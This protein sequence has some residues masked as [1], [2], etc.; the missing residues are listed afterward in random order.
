[1]QAELTEQLG[2]EKNGAGDK[3][4]E[5]RRN[6]KS[7]KTLRPDQGPMEVEAPRDR[8]GEFEPVIAAKLQRE[9]RG[10]DDKIL[11]VYGLGLPAKAVQENLKDIY[12]VDVS[13]ELVSRVTDEVKGLAG[14]WRARPLEPFYPVIF[15]YALR[16]NIRDEGHISKKAVY[17]ALA[18]RLDGQKE[19]AG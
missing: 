1:M 2:Y 13:P 14:E 11:P 6:G 15:F 4:T 10:F 16:V 3:P 17:L 12:N 18:V 19:I 5:N 7:S 8:E 9:W